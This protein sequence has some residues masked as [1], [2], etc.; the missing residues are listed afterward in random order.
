MTK[1]MVVE[2]DRTMQGLL[3]TLLSMEGYQVILGGESSEEIM[4]AIY[5]EKP[6]FL[7][8]DVYLKKTNGL[9]VVRRLHT[10]PGS[11]LPLVL[12][13]SGRDFSDECNKAGADGFLL[14]P[15]VPSELTGWI[16]EHI[17]QKRG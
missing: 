16:K 1:I 12:M 8:L 10:V 7:L 6:D 2:D 14:K 11:F 13:T 17:E 4:A 9:D 5:Q 15:Y 3:Q